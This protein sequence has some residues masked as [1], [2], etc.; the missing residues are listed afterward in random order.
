[1]D[2]L[3]WCVRNVLAVVL[4]LTA[5]SATAAAQRGSLSATI[6]ARRTSPTNDTVTLHIAVR[7]TPGWHI[8]AAQPGTIG[9]PTE[10]T[11]RLPV[12]WRLV[13]SQW[14]LPVSAVVGRDTVFEYRAPFAVDTKLVTEGPH[15]SGPVQAVIAYGICREVCV[16]GRL[17]LEY[18]V[19]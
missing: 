18:V 3:G 15:R 4:L 16:P 17:T 10:L 14:P 8:G 12:G 19:R 2:R 11:W 5:V 7:M 1:M 6:S 13:S 9:V